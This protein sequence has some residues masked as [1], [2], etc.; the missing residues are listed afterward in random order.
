MRPNALPLTLAERMDLLER[1]QTELMRA[2]NDLAEAV[3]VLA[4]QVN[5]S[6]MMLQKLIDPAD[7]KLPTRE[8][9]K[10][11]KGHWC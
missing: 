1:N 3:A 8:P 9:F 4:M 5:H 7:A 11:H 6:T 2:H 10:R